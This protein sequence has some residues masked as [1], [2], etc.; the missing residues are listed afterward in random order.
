MVACVATVEQDDRRLTRSDLV[1]HFL[2]GLGSGRAS[3]EHRDVRRE[4][5]CFDGL[6]ILRA[7]LDIN[8]DHAPL[9]DHLA[10]AGRV[11]QRAAVS[12]PGLDDDIGLDRVDHFLQPDHVVG[13]LNDR[14]TEPSEAVDVLG[15]PT[16]SQ[17]RLGHKSK[18]LWR[19][20]RVRALVRTGAFMNLCGLII[21]CD[22][23]V[24]SK[25]TSQRTPL[26][27]SAEF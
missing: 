19:G 22:H 12:D 16:D 13:E 21:N 26:P 7:N 20:E 25:C 8:A 10:E 5:M 27:M 6:T 3:L 4:D 24:S 11:N 14:A 18:R 23:V 1:T 15:V 9:A 17:P 2:N